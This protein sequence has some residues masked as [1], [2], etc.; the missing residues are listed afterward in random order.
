MINKE[1]GA[2][3]RTFRENKK[4]SQENVAKE[5]D[6]TTSAFSKI[7]RGIT[8]ASISRLESISKI[9]EVNLSQLLPETSA[10]N[11]YNYGNG[12][13]I[14]SN[15]TGSINVEQ[16]KRVEVLEAQ[17][18]ELAKCLKELGIKKQSIDLNNTTI[19]L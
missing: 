7:E 13:A 19:G 18:A 17:V 15:N 9:L 11:L 16:D 3:I 10:N 8:D 12:S 6:I 1:I 2:K 5:L 4:L 14:I